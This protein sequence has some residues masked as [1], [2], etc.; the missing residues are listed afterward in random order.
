MRTNPSSI[1]YGKINIPTNLLKSREYT[2][3]Q[4][5]QI[6]KSHRSYRKKWAKLLFLTSLTK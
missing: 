3:K 6:I 5:S 4:Q 1:Q 2:Q